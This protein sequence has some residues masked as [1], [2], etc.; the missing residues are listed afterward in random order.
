MKN[1]NVSKK[2]IGN[3]I[4]C[5]MVGPGGTHVNFYV[6]TVGQTLRC[7]WE[8]EECPYVDEAAWRENPVTADEFTNEASDG[9]NVSTMTF[10]EVELLYKTMLKAKRVGG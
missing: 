7:V 9:H 6:D 5:R 1:R 10:E 8:N 2:P 3:G 4:F